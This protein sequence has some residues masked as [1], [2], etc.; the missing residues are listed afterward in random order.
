VVRNVQE[1]VER[2]AIFRFN[3]AIANRQAISTAHWERTL[4]ATVVVDLPDGGEEFT[5][6]GM[7]W[8]DVPE[9]ARYKAAWA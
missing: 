1:F 6:G 4:K 8:S 3:G 2:R 5:S 7:N 9:H